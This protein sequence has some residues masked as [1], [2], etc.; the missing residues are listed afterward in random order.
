MACTGLSAVEYVR[1]AR[2]HLVAEL[3]SLSVIVENL[4]QQGVFTDEEVSKVQVERDDY[5][6]TR[7]ILDLVTK[8]GEAASYEFLKIIDITRR[9]T[10]PPLPSKNKY[11]ASSEKFSLHQWI[12]CFPFKEDRVVDEK[13]LKGIF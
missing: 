11:E 3:R 4:Y 5:D 13:Y 7:K 8:K 1:T 10:L 2:V 9:R 12:S 6:K